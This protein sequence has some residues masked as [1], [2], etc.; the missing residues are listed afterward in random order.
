[1]LAAGR[2]LLVE[3]GWLIL[4]L[5]HSPEVGICVW[6]SKTGVLLQIESAEGKD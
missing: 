5:C 4:A 3:L 6:R 2:E 1:M